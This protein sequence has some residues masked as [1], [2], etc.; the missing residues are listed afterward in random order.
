MHSS[1]AWG[2]HPFPV[3]PRQK[4]G[5]WM[6]TGAMS[7]VIEPETCPGASPLP[8]SVSKQWRSAPGSQWLC[9]SRAA[10]CTFAD[11]MPE[12]AYAS[13]CRVC[14]CEAHVAKSSQ[15]VAKLPRARASSA[16]NV[17]QIP[18]NSLGEEEASKAK[19]RFIFF[20]NRR[21]PSSR[22][23]QNIF[24]PSWLR[25]SSSAERSTLVPGRIDRT[26]VLMC[27]GSTDQIGLIC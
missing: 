23:F 1:P 11:Q 16:R 6:R 2:P 9:G 25:S 18:K 22:M 3:C 20:Y 21:V 7:G 12:S 8:A 14:E 24:L 4:G 27:S 5:L 13:S 17:T 26:T 15:N 19:F 10:S